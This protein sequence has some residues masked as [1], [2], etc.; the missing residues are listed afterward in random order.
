MSD[1]KFVVNQVKFDYPSEYI[2]WV[3]GR[4]NYYGNNLRS[5]TFGTNRREYGPFGKFE[6]YDTIFD[7]RLGDDRQ[8]GGFHGTADEKS[9][10]S[11]GVY[12]NPIKTLG[13]L[14]NE[15]IAK[16]EDDVVLV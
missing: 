6:N 3:S 5:I 13:N 1:Y 4:L 9:V 8:F 14:V 12:C 7:L 15:N 16:L 10:R 11:I 2:T